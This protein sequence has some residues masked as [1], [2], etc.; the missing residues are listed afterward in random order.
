MEESLIKISTSEKGINI[1]CPV[2]FDISVAAELHA[3]LCNLIDEKP[4]SVMLDAKDIEIIDVSILQTLYA[5]M[6]DASQ[7]DIKVSWINVSDVLCHSA[8]LLGMKSSLQLNCQ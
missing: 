6:R 3:S 4:A 7:L 5:F 2:Y 8:G 1:V